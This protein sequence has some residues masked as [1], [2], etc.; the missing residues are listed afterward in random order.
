M[1][2]NWKHFREIFLKS[3]FLNQGARL[4]INGLFQCYRTTKAQVYVDINIE[5]KY[6]LG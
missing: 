1:S 5:S 4:K 6:Q 2:T 3:F